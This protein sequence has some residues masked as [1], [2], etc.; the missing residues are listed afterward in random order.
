MTYKSDSSHICSQEDVERYKIDRINFKNC[1]SCY[2]PV[3]RTDGCP[4]M[5]CKNCHKMFNWNT[6]EMITNT[7][8]NPD[9]IEFMDRIGEHPEE[10]L[11]INFEVYQEML[12]ETLNKLDTMRDLESYEFYKSITLGIW[13]TV[14]L[15]NELFC[16]KLYSNKSKFLF[17]YHNKYTL[18]E[19]NAVAQMLDWNVVQNVDV[20]ISLE[21]YDCGSDLID[22]L[23]HKASYVFQNILIDDVEETRKKYNELKEEINR[24][25]SELSIP[26]DNHIGML[27]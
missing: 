10:E 19:M 5:W 23:I 6:L 7:P 9:R 15:I 11:I 24:K 20:S 27:I 2:V 13:Q 26:M 14:Q 22:C 17:L 12:Q 8:H 21:A 4:H 18:D 25:A 3:E 16:Y 1:P